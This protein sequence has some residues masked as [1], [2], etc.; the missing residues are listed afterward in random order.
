LNDFVET[1]CT[2]S[3]LTGLVNQPMIVRGVRA[4]IL[5][6]ETEPSRTKLSFR[7]K[8]PARGEAPIDVNEMARKF[9]GGGHVFAAGARIDLPL[10]AALARLREVIA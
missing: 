4:S 3:D 9:G 1:G 7:A 10:A 5:L 2:V 8:P 6:A